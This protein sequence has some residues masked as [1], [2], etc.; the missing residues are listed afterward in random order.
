MHIADDFI[1][2]TLS[3]ILHSTLFVKTFSPAVMADAGDK[4]LK[5]GE[6]INQPN[7]RGLSDLEGLE[8]ALFQNDAFVR[9]YK[10]ILSQSIVVDA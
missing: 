1:A 6:Q 2:A 5:L 8:I 7:L 3:D 9:G 10:I 4:L